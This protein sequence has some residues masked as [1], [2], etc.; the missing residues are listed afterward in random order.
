[1]RKWSRSIERK[2]STSMIFTNAE[3]TSWRRTCSEGRA[4][5]ARKP[6][7]D[8]SRRGHFAI[9]FSFP[10]SLSWPSS[11]SRLLLLL[12]SRSQF[13]E[14]LGTCHLSAAHRGRAHSATTS[15]TATGIT[16]GIAPS[17]PKR[18]R[19]SGEG[20]ERRTLKHFAASPVV[21]KQHA[22]EAM[23]CLPEKLEEEASASISHVILRRYRQGFSRR[24]ATRISPS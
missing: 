12:L 14:A 10:P 9:P 13:I 4:V 24:E 23:E 8:S 7:K 21:S 11:F 2:R 18:R 5:R 6:A 16:D 17:Y 3:A 19:N 20:A 1:M 15:A 22:F